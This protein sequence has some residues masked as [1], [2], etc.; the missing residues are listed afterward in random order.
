MGND[1]S[2]L[3]ER[4]TSTSCSGGVTFAY[5]PTNSSLL[6]CSV[7]VQ[8]QKQKDDDDGDVVLTGTEEATHPQGFPRVRSFDF[9]DESS[10]EFWTQ[11]A[12]SVGDFKDR[13]IRRISWVLLDLHLAV[14]R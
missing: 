13:R 14:H 7:V 10:E 12:A 3:R 4:A 2:T 1:C 5:P 11:L 6:C 8:W 9:N